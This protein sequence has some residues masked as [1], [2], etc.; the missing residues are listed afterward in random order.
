M[1]E[2][3]AERLLEVHK[4]VL[5]A[6]ETIRKQTAVAP[7]IDLEG[8]LD[9]MG[10]VP[11]MGTLARDL[12]LKD[13]IILTYYAWDLRGRRSMKPIEVYEFLR[14]DGFPVNYGSVVA[15]IAE[16]AKDGLL[17]RETEGTYRLSRS[18][19]ERV[20][21]LISGKHT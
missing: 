16:L 9:L 14:N 1:T 6:M 2:L 3:T 7:G 19:A 13:Q 18:G 17:I 4:A 5:E 11:H 21:A 10:E 15:R 12:S 20:V 8:W